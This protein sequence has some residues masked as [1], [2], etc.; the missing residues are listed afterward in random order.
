MEIS[1]QPVIVAAF[2]LI[3]S[4]GCDKVAKEISLCSGTPPG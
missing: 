4:I 3:G 1:H 2:I